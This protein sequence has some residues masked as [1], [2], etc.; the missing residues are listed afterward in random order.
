ML[1]LLSVGVCV[2]WIA[3]SAFAGVPSV[4]TNGTFE[5]GDLTGCTDA[6]SGAGEWSA[7]SGTTSPISGN[8]IAAPPEGAFAA[9]SDQVSPA[10]DILYQDVTVP[11]EGHT[12]LSFYVYYDNL[13]G[14]FVTPD[15][16]SLEVENQQFRVDV[17]DPSASVDSVA[18]GDVLANVFRTH[19]GDP[20]TLGP[21]LVRFNLTPWDGQTVRLRFAETDNDYYFLASFDDVAISTVQTTASAM[22]CLKKPQMRDDGTVGQFFDISAADWDPTDPGSIF[23]Q[24]T[25]AIYVQGYGTM[26]QIS[27][28]VTYG[29]DPAKFTDS[30]YKVNESGIPT[31]AGLSPADWGAVYEYYVLTG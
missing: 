31:P 13:N 7:Y 15:T 1:V 14:D 3:P 10:E 8:P 5:T 27:D 23:Y 17:M 9:T 19:V 21:M 28:L 12:V 2:A 22:V 20:A 24:S 18:P 16:L 4:V 30:G 26:C 25:P 29:G 11:A 6:S